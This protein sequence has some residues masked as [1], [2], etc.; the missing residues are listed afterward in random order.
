M[1]EHRIAPEVDGI[2]EHPYSFRTVPEI[3][4]A[5]STDA[6]LKRDGFATADSRGTF[7]SQIRMYRER[8]AKNNGPK[9]LWL[10][11]WGFPV[12]Q[13]KEAKMYA[14]RTPEAQAKCILRRFAETFGLGVELSVYYDLKDDGKDPYEAEHNFGL[15][16]YDLTKKP[17]YGAVQRIAR[18][19][20]PYTPVPAAEV[21]VFVPDSRPEQ[22]PLQWDGTRLAAPGTI[23]SY[24]FSD[25]DAGGKA[26]MVLLWSA[27]RAGGDLNARVGDVEI[28]LHAPAQSVRSYNIYEDT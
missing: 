15:V 14:G 26:A 21:N 3:V 11:E 6:M 10:T 2:V 4:S 1:L 22:W 16:K 28:V 20:L 5:G 25:R 13:E 19:M 18:F 23:M 9:E 12:H 17:A 24:A 7:A 27:E 8:S